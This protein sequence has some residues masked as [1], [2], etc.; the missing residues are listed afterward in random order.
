M[1]AAERVAAFVD[2][3]G[4]VHEIALWSDDETAVIRMADLRELLAG[5]VGAEH[6]PVIRAAL[7]FALTQMQLGNTEDDSAPA[8]RAAL[9]A[10]LKEGE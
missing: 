7:E 4:G 10:L 9:A 5:Y 1:S 3:W 2:R 8:M 6:V